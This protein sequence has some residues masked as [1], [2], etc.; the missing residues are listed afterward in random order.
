MM[1]CRFHNSP[2]CGRVSQGGVGA[3]DA[4]GTL[5]D[6]QDVLSLNT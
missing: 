6:M 4:A 1:E 2:S 3:I 5:L